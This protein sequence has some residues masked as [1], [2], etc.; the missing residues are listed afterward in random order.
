[1][2]L[3]IKNYIKIEKTKQIPI[4]K[5]NTSSSNLILLSNNNNNKYSLNQ[6]LFDPFKSSPPNNF[7]NN[8]QTRMNAFQSIYLEKQDHHGNKIINR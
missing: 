4:I 3:Q 6:D 7:M 5:N 2:D 8:L 1:M